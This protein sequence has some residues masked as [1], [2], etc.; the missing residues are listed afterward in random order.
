MST[1][2]EYTTSWACRSVAP[3]MESVSGASARTL[4]REPRGSRSERIRW[5]A[6]T[7]TS[8]NAGPAPSTLGQVARSAR[9][10]RPGRA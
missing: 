3:P 7:R 4:Y 9:I 5:S 6:A 1:E 8:P 2:D 10:P